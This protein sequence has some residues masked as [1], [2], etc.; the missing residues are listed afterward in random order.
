MSGAGTIITGIRKRTTPRRS[1]FSGR[2]RIFDPSYAQAWAGLADAYAMS[3]RY[4]DASP[5]ALDTAIAM[6]RRALNIDPELAEGYKALGLAQESKGLIKEGLESYSKAVAINPNY[7][8]VV[9]NIG[10]LNYSLGN[11]DE[12]LKWLRKAVELQPGFARFYALIGLQYLYLGMEPQ[13]LTWL[14]RS[15][16]FQPGFIFPDM[17]LASL[18]VYEGQPEEALIRIKRILAAHPDEPNA[19]NVAGDAESAAK[20][21]REAVPYYEKLVAISSVGG[22]PGNKLGF[23]MAKTGDAARA[24]KI[25]AE[26]LAACLEN[27]RLD[28]PGSPL[29]YYVAEAYALQGKTSQ[30]LESLEKSVAA[31]NNDR[32]LFLDPLLESIRGTDRYLAITETLEK[33]LEAMR[34]HVRKLGLEK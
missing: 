15:L 31:G 4:G 33:R 23:V 5:D 30:A 19:L 16:E 2:R 25:I 27:P 7:A 10:S 18:S 1:P 6:G 26:S 28:Q 29:R 12:A 24:E 3:W 14:E 32:W 11:Y 9:A 8:P 34:E 17:V 22:A 20:R 21:Y 13:A